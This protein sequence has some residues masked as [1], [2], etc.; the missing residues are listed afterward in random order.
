[1]KP[2]KGRPAADLLILHTIIMIVTIIIIIIKT[3][4]SASTILYLLTFIYTYAEELRVYIIEI[5][6]VMLTVFRIGL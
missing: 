2:P 4:L 6:I 3:P 5:H 1:M